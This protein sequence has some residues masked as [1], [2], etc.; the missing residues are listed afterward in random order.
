MNARWRLI[1][2]ALLVVGAIAHAVGFAFD[3]RRALF[4]YLTAFAFFVTTALGCLVLLQVTH[5]AKARWFAPLRRLTEIGAATLPLF[6]VL[7]IPLVLGAHELYRWARPIG[8]LPAADMELLHHKQAWLNVPFFAVR[9]AV[10]L[11]GAAAVA[12]LLARWSLLQDRDADPVLQDRMRTLAAGALPPIA[13]AITFAS[14]D[15]LMSLEPL[16]HST[17]YGMYVFT[18]GFV[19][20]LALVGLVATRLHAYV[21]TA[22]RYAV[23]KLLLAMVIFWAYIGLSQ[24]LIVWIA[25]VPRE[26]AF[27]QRRITEGWRWVSLALGLGHFGLPFLA[28]LSRDLK[29][30]RTGLALV[31]AWLLLAHYLDVYWLVMPVYGPPSLHWLDLSALALVGGACTLAAAIRYRGRPLFASGDPSWE[32]ALRYRGT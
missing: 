11:A 20:A 12:W 2:L 15:W 3:P 10:W 14:F 21:E 22:H 5:A 8:D 25:N 31:C 29:R 30:S 28:L 13:F 27:Y 23:G 1:G 24:L 6:L 4:S 7:A 17:V 19:A 9:T 16:F 32:Q 26:A 18:G